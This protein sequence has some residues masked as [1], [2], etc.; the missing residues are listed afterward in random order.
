M[1]FLY[2]T[3]KGIQK[4]IYNMNHYDKIKLL[5]EKKK[6]LFNEM[7]DTGIVDKYTMRRYTMLIS[8]INE[9]I[10]DEEIKEIKWKNLNKLK[11]VN[12]KIV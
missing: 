3:K 2:E 5:I 4:I 12:M 6:E 9:F 10:I 8:M 7:M 1:D 11:D